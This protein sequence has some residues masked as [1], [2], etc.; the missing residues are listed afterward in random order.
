MI[1]VLINKK[2]GTLLSRLGEKNIVL[3]YSV[4]LKNYFFKI[5]KIVSQITIAYAPNAMLWA[6]GAHSDVCAAYDN[7]IS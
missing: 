1:I 4:L 6:I 7:P 5:Q 2:A 3:F